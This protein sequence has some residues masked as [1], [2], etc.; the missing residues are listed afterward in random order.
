MFFKSNLSWINPYWVHTQCINH[1]PYKIS[2]IIKFKKIS[3]YQN[4]NML[5]TTNFKSQSKDEMNKTLE[6]LYQTI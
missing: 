2:Y 5:T 3:I 1:Q 6:S 4:V